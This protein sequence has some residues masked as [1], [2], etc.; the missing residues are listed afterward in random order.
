MYGKLGRYPLIVNCCIKVIRYWI[1]I[2][3]ID[4]CRLP[5]QAYQILY[6]KN[7][8]KVVKNTLFSLGF[9]FAWYNQGVDSEQMFI[10]Q[11]K[12][13]LTDVCSQDWLT[14]INDSTRYYV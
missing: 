12:L 14:D 6:S 11:I 9:G 3:K 5:K 1:R 10:A 4:H 2:V 13:R 7:W 8:V